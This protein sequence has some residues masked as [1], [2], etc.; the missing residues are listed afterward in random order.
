MPLGGSITY[1]QCSSH[2]NGYRS[3]LHDLLIKDG[4]EVDIVGSRNHGSMSN[5]AHEGWRG[6]RIEQIA[7]KAEKSVPRYLPNLFTLNAGSNDCLQ[8]FALDR[9]EERVRAL[10]ERLWD[11]APGSTVLL[12]TLLVCA[13]LRTEMRVLR[14]NENLRLLAEKLAEE[15]RRLV[16]VDMHGSDGPGVA[17]LSADGVHPNDEGYEKMAVKWFEGVR[18]AD[19]RGLLEHSR[20]IL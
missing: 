14:F 15:R 9:A 13:S 18:E 1:G 4:Y 12:S 20:P 7:K 16:L 5:N 6:F 3:L 19:E 8:D 2:G 17:D 10:L 11:C